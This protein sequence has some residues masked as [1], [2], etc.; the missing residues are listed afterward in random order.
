MQGV[1]DVTGRT[2]WAGDVVAW[3]RGGRYDSVVIAEAESFT[4]KGWIRI[5]V[6]WADRPDD[7]PAGSVHAVNPRRTV[8][9][10]RSERQEAANL[11]RDMRGR[12]ERYA[13][14]R[15]ATVDG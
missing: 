13:A 8:R 2:V 4:D 15:K 9:I 7:I 5:R 12:A 10:E 1:R 11:V 14:R 6:L 3:F